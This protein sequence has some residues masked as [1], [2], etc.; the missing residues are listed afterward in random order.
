MT[1]L[2]TQFTFR[3][4]TFTQLK[5]VKDVALFERVKEGK[6]RGYE[7]I[8]I[9]DVPST[10]WPNGKVTEAH[11]GYPGDNEFGLKGWYY[12]KQDLDGAEKRF[13]VE[14]RREKK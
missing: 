11:E 9:K 5:R 7:V 13:K 14:S 2:S 3:G 8:R 10:T 12:M 1:P 6:T 4:E